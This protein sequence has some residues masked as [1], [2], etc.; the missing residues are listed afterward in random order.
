MA[1]GMAIVTISAIANGAWLLALHTYVR[2][3]PDVGKNNN[4]V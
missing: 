2:T 1:R 3:V 4:I